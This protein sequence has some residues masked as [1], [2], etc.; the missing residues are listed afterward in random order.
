METPGEETVARRKALIIA[1]S[2]YNK[3]NHLE[4]LPFCKNDGNEIISVLK[5]QGYEI[6][7]NHKLVGYVKYDVMRKAIYD[8]FN[9]SKITFNDALLLYYSG[10]GFYYPGREKFTPDVC[11]GSSET[12]PDDPSWEGIP[13]NEIERRAN[14]CSAR[15]VVTILDC[16]HSG[17]AILGS[18]GQ[19][20][21]S[22]LIT[23]VFDKQHSEGEGR[24]LLAASQQYEEAYTLVDENHSIFTHYLLKGL[25]G[26]KKSVDDNGNVTAFTLGRYVFNTISSLDPK[27]RPKQKPVIKAETSGDIVLAEYPDLAKAIHEEPLA[28]DRGSR[29]ND[30]NPTRQS[31][32]VLSSTRI[33]ILVVVAIVATLSFG[34]TY[35]SQHIPNTPIPQNP[36]PQFVN[37]SGSSLDRLQ[38]LLNNSSLHQ[39]TPTPFNQLEQMKGGVLTNRPGGNVMKY[40]ITGFGNKLNEILANNSIVIVN[41]SSPSPGKFT[42]ELPRSLIDT[43]DSNTSLIGFN[44]NFKVLI[45]GNPI[46]SLDETSTTPD[47]TITFS[48]PK[49]S[50]QFEIIGST[51]IPN[52][53]PSDNSSLSTMRPPFPKA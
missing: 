32:G 14:Y 38:Q 41:I 47:R 48:F 23:D 3:A 26:E 37:E 16:C 4:N 36:P 24:C 13:Y 27:K 53:R 39:I 40:E 10:H 17:A 52:H 8:F 7:D 50:Q 28:P 35:W 33:L 15:S 25:R 6:S 20:E 18:K 30:Y 22:K 12:N 45:D 5:S 42:L 1:V 31:K 51:T 34:L 29:N 44:N 9:D 11:L 43:E 49:G 2:E 46:E 21:G 19:N